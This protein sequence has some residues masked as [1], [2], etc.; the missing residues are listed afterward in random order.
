MTKQEKL[1]RFREIFW[2]AFHFPKLKSDKI[3]EIYLQLEELNTI[4]AGPLFSIYETGD[5]KFIFEDDKRF[6][7]IK[8]NSDLF[9]RNV[10]I[11]THYKQKVDEANAENEAEREDV[12]VLHYQI[13]LKMELADLA[14]AI[15][16]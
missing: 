2:D 7:A 16:D 9:E 3:G 10:S 13:D 14:F 12:K 15:I 1:E 8:T 11:I 5:C 4:L 6:P